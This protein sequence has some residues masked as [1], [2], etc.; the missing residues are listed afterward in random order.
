MTRVREKN[1]DDKVVATVVE[2]L[3]G[4]SGRLS[5][6]A[7]IEAIARRAGL[8]YTRQALHRHE[9][10][11]LAFTVRKKALSGRDEQPCEAMSPELQV[12]VDRIARLD[13]ENRRLTAENHNLLEQFARWAYNAQTRNLSKEFLNSPL[14][15]VD[16][17]QS[18]RP[19]LPGKPRAPWRS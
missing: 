1:L 6:K 13:A 3:D 12:A 9:R 11:R 14:P 7:L 10:I 2:V 18:E 17:E 16:R 15:G 19:R 5:W 4:W 8:S